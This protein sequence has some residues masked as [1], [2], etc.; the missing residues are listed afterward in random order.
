MSEQPVDTRPTSPPRKAKGGV[1]YRIER[2]TKTKRGGGQLSGYALDITIRVNAGKA[3][4]LEDHNSTRDV[5]PHNDLKELV[6][7]LLA[8]LARNQDE[9]F[10]R[11]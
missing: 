11:P 1:A 7:T 6:E 2:R 5:M 8:E 3:C 10:G 9:H 4:F